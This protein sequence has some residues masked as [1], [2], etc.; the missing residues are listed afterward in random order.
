[1]EKKI[2][3]VFIAIILSGFLIT[4]SVFARAAEKIDSTNQFHFIKNE[5]NSGV[6]FYGNNEHEELRTD[7]STE[8]EE[9]FSGSV[10]YRIGSRFWNFLDNKQEELNFNFE[11]GPLFGTGNFVDSM[12]NVVIEADHKIYGLRTNAAVGY[13]SRFYYDQKNYTLV[14]INGWARYDLYQQSSEGT[15]LDS[16]LVLSD[17]NQLD[18]KSKFK[19]GFQAKAGLGFG[20]LNPMNHFMVA[21]YLMDKY[22]KGRVF[23]EI[24]LE[25]LAFEIGKIKLGRNTKTENL[26]KKE[27]ETITEFL[28]TKMLLAAPE[29][30][31]ADWKMGEFRP[32]LNGKRIEM[33]PFF[34]YF[35]REPD[36]IYGGF[37]EFRNHTY[38]NFNWT[39]YLK[40]NLNYN[41][42]KTQ[43]WIL[44]E[45]DF[46]WSFYPNL[47]T[48]FD[49]GLKYVPGVV[50]NGFENI[51]PVKH[52]FIPYIEYFTQVN[53]KTRVNF[54]IAWKITD[55]D[56][57]MLAGPEFSLAVY[58]SKY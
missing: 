45:T 10:K 37:V 51:E 24:E 17:Y 25:K 42:Y 27:L 20:W 40:V 8:K 5:I 2:T 34:N 55:S 54:A 43:D 16:N 57:F 44:L 56:Q 49:F 46:G 14:K 22:Y 50:V 41:R 12:A 19:Y 7:F 53:S 9:L 6:V 33:G 36:F 1:M 18:K 3:G 21:E 31:L 39:R 30:L 52:N 4:N 28:S 15:V 23:S 47:K 11:T 38:Q 58:R 29:N 32:R 48:Q 35:N 26:T 13:S